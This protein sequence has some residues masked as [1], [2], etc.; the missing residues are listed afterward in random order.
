MGTDARDTAAG[1]AVIAGSI[2]GDLR[3]M[4]IHDES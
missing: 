4:T 2:A 1:G 3:D